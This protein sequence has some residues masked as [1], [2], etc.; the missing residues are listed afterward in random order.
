MESRWDT[1]RSGA[2]RNAGRAARGEGA[3]IAARGAFD[4]RVDFRQSCLGAK[5]ERFT[6][7]PAQG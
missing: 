5:G 3:L 6:F 2:F 4:S 7:N 1:C